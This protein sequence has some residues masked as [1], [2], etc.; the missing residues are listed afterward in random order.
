MR[1]SNHR[2]GPDALRMHVTA[3]GRAGGDRG[4]HGGVRCGWAVSSGGGSGVYATGYSPC[5]SPGT[6]TC[7]LGHA[8]QTPH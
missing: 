3:F 6:E 5:H 2:N 4:G 1:L 8:H 7:G